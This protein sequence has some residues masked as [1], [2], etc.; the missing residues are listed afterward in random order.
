MEYVTTATDTITSFPTDML[1]IALTFILLLIWI[2]Y[3]GRRYALTAI[4]AFYPAAFL[5]TQFPYLDAVGSADSAS[6]TFFVHLGIFAVLVGASFYV[7]RRYIKRHLTRPEGAKG[8]LHALL[9]TIGV[10]ALVLVTVT[11]LIP[12]DGVYTISPRVAGVFAEQ[13][14]FWWMVG[15]LVI[16][17]A[18]SK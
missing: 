6:N 1:V 13:Y 15:P 12:I 14:I 18:T 8:A 9:L 17:F 3:S 4:M 2:F 11:A 10:L 7:L 5:F 16:L